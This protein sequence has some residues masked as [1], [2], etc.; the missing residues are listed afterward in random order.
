M[1]VAGAPG[2]AIG[3][4]THTYRMV[5]TLRDVEGFSTAEVAEMLD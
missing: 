4:L 1:T 5:F 2:P 3:Q